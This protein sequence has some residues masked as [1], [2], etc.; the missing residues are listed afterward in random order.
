MR[1]RD[2][3]GIRVHQR[4]LNVRRHKNR[5]LQRSNWA[6]MVGGDC[7]RRT[8]E[9]CFVELSTA[10]GNKEVSIRIASLLRV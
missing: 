3:H 6:T 10:C 7:H 1:V 8:T 2:G 4:P 5:L 9:K